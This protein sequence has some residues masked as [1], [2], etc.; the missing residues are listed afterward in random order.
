MTWELVIYGVD[1]ND[2]KNLDGLNAILK[3]GYEP[4]AVTKDGH[5]YD[6]HLRRRAG[7]CR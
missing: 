7:V 5:I 2:Q 4:F 3:Q 1:V 6:Y